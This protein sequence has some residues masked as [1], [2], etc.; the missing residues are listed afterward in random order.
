MSIRASRAFS[1]FDSYQMA[2]IP[3]RTR[4]SRIT[5]GSTKAAKPSSPSPA[6][7]K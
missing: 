6:Q 3:F 1:A 2:T 5:K 4:M 7:K